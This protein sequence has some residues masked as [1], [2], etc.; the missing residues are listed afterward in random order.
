MTSGKYSA[1][2]MLELRTVGRHLQR[3]SARH[4]TA[5]G[6]LQKCIRYSTPL[7]CDSVFLG[8]RVRITLE[9]PSGEQAVRRDI[10]IRPLQQA[11]D[12][13]VVRA[14]CALERARVVC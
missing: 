8:V 9:N 12:D 1:W 4:K 2:L 13:S 11:Q 3:P 6:R 7:N 14:Q 5:H 10:P